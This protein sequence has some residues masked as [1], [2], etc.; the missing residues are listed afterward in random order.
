MKK[1]EKI[2]EAV[3]AIAEIFGKVV[4]ENEIKEI[5]KEFDV[6]SYD[7]TLALKNHIESSEGWTVDD[8]RLLK[9]VFPLLSITI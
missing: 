1:Q 2:Q 9:K 8:I 3:A 4:Y 7:V 5:L 6:D